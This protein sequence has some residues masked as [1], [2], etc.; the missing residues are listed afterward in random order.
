MIWTVTEGGD[1]KLSINGLCNRGRKPDSLTCTYT[2]GVWATV[3]TCSYFFSFPFHL[4]GCE[5][6][7]WD[8]AITPSLPQTIGI[9]ICP[10]LDQS[11]SFLV[12]FCQSRWRKTTASHRCSSREWGSGAASCPLT[13]LMEGSLTENSEQPEPLAPLI[14][15]PEFS[16]SCV[17]NFPLKK[18]SK[19]SG[20]DELR[21]GHHASQSPGAGTSWK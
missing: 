21:F 4:L 6:I 20:E 16:I 19:G 9:G 3:V 13:H 17:L 15:H 2:K 12:T 5:Y 8:W 18:T 7:R 1:L 14:E 11:V 10:S